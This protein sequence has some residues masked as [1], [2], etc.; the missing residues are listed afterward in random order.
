MIKVHHDDDQEE[1]FRLCGGQMFTV[2]DDLNALNKSA[3]SSLFSASDLDRVRPDN[4]HF[5]IHNIGMGSQENYGQNRNGDAFPKQACVDHVGTFVTHGHF[6]REHRNRDPKE[7]IGS[8][9]LAG[10]N[11]VL[12]RV[13]TVMW[14]SRKKAEKEYEMAKAGKTLAFSMS[15]FPAGTLVR[16]ADGM[17]KAIE[18][19][20]PTDTVLTHRGNPGVVSHIMRRHYS[21]AGVEFHAYGLPDP[22]RCTADHGVWARPTKK[23]LTECPVCGEKFTRL[24]AHLHQKKD[25][26]HRAAHK[27]LGRYAEGFRAAD[28]LLPGDYIRQAFDHRVDSE[29]DADWA[30]IAGYYAA[31]GNLFKAASYSTVNGKK[32]GPYD[33][34]RTE[35]T[36]HENEDLHP[37]ATGSLCT[38]GF[39]TSELVALSCRAPESCKVTLQRGVWVVAKELRT[40]IRREAFQPGADALES[41]KPKDNFG[42][43]V[44]RRRALVAHTRNTDRHYC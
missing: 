16:M 23:S 28:A 14:G 19:V 24:M 31:E 11:P 9:K 8:I 35:F 30:V 12:H 1:L 40:T 5:L 20:L 6:F 32:Y 21:G 15:C 36:F 33:S 37:G 10:Y 27:D 17:S 38:S 25:A 44:G 43:V 4:D 7:S 22:V 41:E 34:F 2:Y 26:K 13:E 29:G 39:P 42:E 3:A 18:E